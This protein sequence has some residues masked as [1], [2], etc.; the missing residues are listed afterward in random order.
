MKLD[1][2]VHYGFPDLLRRTLLWMAQQVVH[3]TEHHLADITE[4]LGAG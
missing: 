3:E 1:R 4:N 2:I